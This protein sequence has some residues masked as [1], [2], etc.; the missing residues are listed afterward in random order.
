M[1]YDDL[2]CAG[3]SNYS[4]AIGLFESSLMGV[5]QEEKCIEGLSGNRVV[6]NSF[7]L[8]PLATPE[9]V[10]DKITQRELEY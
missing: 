5:R 8:M 4:I 7:Q 10:L 3:N 2:S 9:S 1:L 6:C